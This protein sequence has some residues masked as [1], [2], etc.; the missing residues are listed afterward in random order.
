MVR[1]ILGVCEKNSVQYSKTNIHD[2]ISDILEIYFKRAPSPNPISHTKQ[3]NP[4]A[5]LPSFFLL[6]FF[7]S[8]YLPSTVIYGASLPAW[9][10]VGCCR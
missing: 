4:Y 6:S 3:A 8:A 10:C 1:I 2:E 9:H 7:F 5:L